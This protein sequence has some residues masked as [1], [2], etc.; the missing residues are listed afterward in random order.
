M[1]SDTHLL[2]FTKLSGKSQDFY[3]LVGIHLKTYQF[4]E[5]FNLL[6]ETPTAGPNDS[7][8]RI[9]LVFY[10]KSPIEAELTKYGKNLAEPVKALSMTSS[11]QWH[12]YLLPDT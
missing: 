4:S 3:F 5:I 2:H 6:S 8:Q 7:I 12:T 11:E 9:H 10:G 1:E